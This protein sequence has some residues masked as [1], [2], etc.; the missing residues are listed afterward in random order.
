MSASAIVA[1]ALA[2]LLP[3]VVVAGGLGQST[4]VRDI[5]PGSDESG[6]L[7]SDPN[8]LTDVNGTLFFS[9][10]GPGGRE[11]YKSDGTAQGTVRINVRP[12]FKSAN[13][14]SLTVL[15]SNL[16][17][18]ADGGDGHGRELWVSDGTA[19]GTHIVKDIRAGAKSSSPAALTV[20]GGKVYFGA[21]GG[22]GLGRELWVS[23]GTPVGTHIVRDVIPG[24]TSS[25]PR[26]LVAVGTRLFFRAKSPASPTRTELW[27]TYGMAQ[28][29]LKIPVNTGDDAAQLTRVGSQLFFISSEAPNGPF[30]PEWTLRV[31]RPGANTSV[32]LAQLPECADPS[33]SSNGCHVDCGNEFCEA[34]NEMT[35]VGNLLF[36]VTDTDRLWRSDGTRAGTFKLVRLGG[37]NLASGVPCAKSFTDVNGTLFYVTPRIVFS[38]AINDYEHVGTELWKSDGTVAGTAA[39]EVFGPYQPWYWSA[40]CPNCYY[41]SYLVGASAAFGGQYYFQGPDGALWR[42]DGTDPGTTR[43][44][45]GDDP[46]AY[47]APARFAVSGGKLFMTADD[48]ATGRELWRFDP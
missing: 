25:D 17:F 41:G 4:L 39:V 32:R 13:P 31:V 47:W 46:C 14:T 5:S 15:G 42:S 36:F 28:G 1:F 27:A 8:E 6:P 38:N 24:S 40:P 44:C 18:A 19:L 7:S 34:S 3:Q 23:D 26:Q 45:L 35:A 10:S 43:A 48:F 21:N 22:G 12:G 11:L 9:A 2:A 20:M 30:E 29:T 33:S 16:F 37:C